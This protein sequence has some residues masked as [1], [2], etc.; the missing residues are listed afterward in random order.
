MAGKMRSDVEHQIGDN[1]FSN[2]ACEYTFIIACK[3]PY[4]KRYDHQLA[5][6]LADVRV[7]WL[8][9]KSCLPNKDLAC[10]VRKLS[11]AWPVLY[12]KNSFEKDKKPINSEISYKI[13]RQLGQLILPR[14][15]AF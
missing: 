6:A 14:Q 11:P 9:Y 15:P 4:C 3:E 7:F 12:T 13:H 8:F 2:Y 10:G 1:Y 5:T